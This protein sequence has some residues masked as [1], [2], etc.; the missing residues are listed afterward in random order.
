[1]YRNTAPVNN[2]V[3]VHLSIRH[4]LA[5]TSF[6]QK[7]SFHCHLFNSSKLNKLACLVLYL[8][9]SLT[10][11]AWIAPSQSTGFLGGSYVSLQVWAPYNHCKL[12]VSYVSE[13]H[14]APP[15]PPGLQS[16]R[17]TKLNTKHST[18]KHKIKQT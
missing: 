14:S 4:P 16:P 1:M 11:D 3:L 12:G 8:S 6:I 5:G 10:W 2:S 7:T 13:C 18:G 15:R 9:R 17:I